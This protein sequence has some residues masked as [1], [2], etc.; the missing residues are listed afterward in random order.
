MFYFSSE[1]KLATMRTMNIL[2]GT[3]ALLITNPTNIRYLTGFTG[4]SP[5]ERE[6]YILLTAKKTFLFTNSLYMEKAKSLANVTVMQISRE[7]PIATEVKKLCEKLKLDI[8]GFEENNLTVAEY[9]RLTEQ[10]PAVRFVATRNTI[11]ERRQ[12]KSPK[13]LANIKLAVTLTDQCFKFITRRIRPGVTERRLAAEIEGFFKYKGAEL[14]F[15][16]IVAFNDH[17][18]QP[19]WESKG[20]NPLRRGS[21]ILLDFGAKVNGYCA[22]M[23]RVVFLGKPKTEWV[24]AYN[25]VLAAQ[26]KAIDL[27]KNGV[28]NGATLDAAA[29]EVIAEAGLPPYAHSLG[30]CVG[31]DIH[32]NPRLSDKKAET[33][34]TGM[35]FSVEPGVYLAGQYGIRIEDLVRLTDT[36]VEILSKAPKNV[37]IL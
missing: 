12:M 27:L 31:L 1:I 4:A 33:L 10:L 36:G 9:V 18:S 22:D 29:R 28:R 8:L 19:H 21:L 17:A 35:V 26:T 11:E 13:E 34:K 30:H 14:A 16:P 25:T 24:T 37:T 15:S 20:N 23:T 3:D 7:D 6:A 32:E 2:T 5:E